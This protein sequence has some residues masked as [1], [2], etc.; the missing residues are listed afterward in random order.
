MLGA[1]ADNGGPTWTHAL[2]PD[3]PAVDAGDDNGQAFDQRG[4]GF[5]RIVG[6]AA[7]I[8]AYELEE[9]GTGDEIFA[10]DFELCPG[11]PSY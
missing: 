3:S 5:P 6:K 10:A 2:P 8:G 9:H 11:C 7:D 4:T 1:L